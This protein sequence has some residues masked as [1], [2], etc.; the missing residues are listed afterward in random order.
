MPSLNEA[1]FSG[2][3]LMNPLLGLVQ[4]FR[5]N[6]YALLADIKKAFLNIFLSDVEDQNRFSFVLMLIINFIILDTRLFCLG[7]LLHLLF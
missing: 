6:K 7:M 3:D 5:T 4:L 2:I 1:A